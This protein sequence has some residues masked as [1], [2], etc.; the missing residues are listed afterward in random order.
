[1]PCCRSSAGWLQCS[2]ASWK[3]GNGNAFKLKHTERWSVLVEFST[4]GIPWSLDLFIGQPFLAQSMQSIQHNYMLDNK[5]SFNYR[6]VL[7]LVKGHS[8]AEEWYVAT[9]THHH[10]IISPLSH[11]HLHGDAGDFAALKEIMKNTSLPGPGSK[12]APPTSLGIQ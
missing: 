5:H 2:G 9:C 1:M 8:A 3:S 7:F 12:I 6:N 4:H 11:Y 10:L